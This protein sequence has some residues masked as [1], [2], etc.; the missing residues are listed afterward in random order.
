ME[1]DFWVDINPVAKGRPRFYTAGKFVGTYTPE[2]TMI[3]EAQ[4]LLASRK[5]AP[6]K[7]LQGPVMI[8]LDIGMAIPASRKKTLPGEFHIIKPD[9]DNL[10]KSALDPLNGLFW[11]DDAQICR[12]T[13]S[14]QYSDKP[15]IRYRIYA[16]LDIEE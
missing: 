12:V 14:K 9:I 3:F 4:L 8:W 5:H 11:K 2:K 10:L 15:G 7:P 1:I 13:M 16:P 6:K